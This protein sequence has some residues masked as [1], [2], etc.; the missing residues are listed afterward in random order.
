VARHATLRALLAIAATNDLEMEQIDV[1][2]AFLNGPLE[3]TFTWNRRHD[4]VL[5]A[6]FS[7]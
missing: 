1:M 6:R 2:T 5:M 3:K 4:T 7:G